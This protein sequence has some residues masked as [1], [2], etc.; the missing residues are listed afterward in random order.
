MSCLLFFFEET[1]KNKGTSIKRAKIKI[2]TVPNASEDAEK[3]DLS[4]TAGWNV[5]E[6]PIQKTVGQ[7][8]QKSNIPLPCNPAITLLGIYSKEKKTCVHSKTYTQMCV[9]AL[10]TTKHEP[11]QITVNSVKLNTWHPYQ[12][13][14]SY[15]KEQIIDTYNGPQ[16]HHA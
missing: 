8:L 12:L 2:L 4:Y 13:L 14:L 9:V 16:G 3:L 10:F 1:I 5:M 6:L 7:F 15:K 11:T